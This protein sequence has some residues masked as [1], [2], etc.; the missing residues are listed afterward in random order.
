MSLVTQINSLITRIGTEF[1]TTKTIISGNSTG[2]L[3]GL[4]TTAKTNLVAAINELKTG[5]NTLNTAVG[6]NKGWY[7]TSAALVSANPSCNAGDYAIVG[8]TDTVWIWDTDGTPQWR[9]GDT[10]GAVTSVN[11]NTGAVVIPQVT[12]AVDGLMIAADKTKLNGIA[13]GATANS[14]DAT[15]LARANH[16]GT[17]LAATISD[18]AAQ[19]IAQVLTG[20]STATNAAVVATD[21][22]LVA[23]GKIQAQMNGHFGQGGAVHA[24]AANAGAAGFMSGTDK[25]KLDAIAAGA[26]ANDTDAN[27]KNRAN[28]TGTQ[29]A[30]TISDFAA[31][32]IAQVLTGLSV[33]TAT[34]VAASDSILIAIGKLQAQHTAHYG[35]GGAS[36]ADA[37]TSTSGFMSGTDKTKL[38]GVATGATANSADATLLARA[39]HTGT[40]LA[41]TISDLASA[42]IAVVLTGFSTASS[43]A[44]T[45]T[46]SVLTAFGKIQGQINAHFGAGGAVHAN[47]IAAGASGFMTGTDKTKLDGLSNYVHPS[48]DGN[49][50]VPA[51]STTNNLKVLKAGATAGVFAWGNVA[52]SELTGVPTTIVGYGLTDVYSKTEIGDPTTDCVAAFNTAII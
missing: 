2:D 26:T 50:H 24:N 10:K 28:H 27:L 39:N 23:F 4:S 30:A 49:L 43:A 51:T 25:A 9:D 31:S 46:D 5:Y 29:L 14:A 13:T 18:F 32:V 40:Q 7:A 8:A 19:V 41:A 6:K 22:I 52:F 44:V 16:T 36:H 11:G 3:T 48:T 12:T 1:K 33:V 47:V 34:A 35:S 38:N 20:F 15:L 21:T 45:A 17:Q 42:V 37:T